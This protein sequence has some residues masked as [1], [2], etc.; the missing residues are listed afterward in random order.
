M[1]FSAEASFAL[2]GCLLPAGGYCVWNAFKKN[3]AL[4]GLA[5]IPLAFGA[6]Q[7]CEG[8]AWSGINHDHLAFARIAAF[9]YL[10]FALSFWPFWIPFC[11]FLTEANIRMKLLMGSLALLGLVGGLL[12]YVPILA[13]PEVLTLKVRNRSLFYDIPKSPAMEVLPAIWWEVL[14]VAVVGIPLL[15]SPTRGFVLLGIA[16]VVAAVAS[17]LFYSY[18]FI[19]VWCFFAAMLSLYICFSFR[20][21]PSTV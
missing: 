18:A 11:A 14:Y 5:V 2:S 20:R 6:Q 15:I 9:V 10:Y 19:S 7:L 16:L 4:L 3:K 13:N 21:L 8:L 17:H 1:C 12:L